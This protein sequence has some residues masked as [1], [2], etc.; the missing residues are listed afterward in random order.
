MPV[1]NSSR[2]GVRSST[3]GRGAVDRPA[4]LVLH[5]AR[6]VDRVA[7]QVEDA[8]ERA[9]ADRHRDRRAGV[10]DLGAAAEAVGGVHGD[11]AH[12]VV[13]EV[14]L[15]LDDQPDRARRPRRRPGSRSRAR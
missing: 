1:S 9:L 6:V 8:A 3:D 13:A 10:A 14:L 12:A 5:V 15:H 4:L 2:V 11:A 7:E